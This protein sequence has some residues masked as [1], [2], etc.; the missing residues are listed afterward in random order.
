M[1]GL[2]FKR[3]KTKDESLNAPAN[4]K[5]FFIKETILFYRG[6]QPFLTHSDLATTSF[7]QLKY[8]LNNN[9]FNVYKCGYAIESVAHEMQ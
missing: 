6:F 2:N 1:N 7:I 3:I 5:E 4:T 8:N 9:T